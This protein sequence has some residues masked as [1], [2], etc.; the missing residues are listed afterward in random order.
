MTSDK[1]LGNSCPFETIELIKHEHASIN[2]FSPFITNYSK[3]LRQFR[4]KYL[5]DSALSCKNFIDS[6]FLWDFSSLIS[7][8]ISSS[9][10]TKYLISYF[11]PNILFWSSNIA[12]VLDLV[13][14]FSVDIKVLLREA[15]AESENFCLWETC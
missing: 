15:R 2:S 1:F 14:S 8:L 10:L 3:V 4:V 5:P 6:I 7:I 9:I 12:K 11:K 13:K